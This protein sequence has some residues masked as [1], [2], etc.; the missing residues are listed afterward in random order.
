MTKG[1]FSGT[2]H[3]RNPCLTASCRNTIQHVFVWVWKT[4]E[5]GDLTK[6]RA[7]VA[8]VFWAKAPTWFLQKAVVPS[9]LF[10]PGFFFFFFFFD[11]L[12][13]VF[14]SSSWETKLRFHPFA[15]TE[16]SFT[17]SLRQNQRLLIAF[18]F[19]N[20]HTAKSRAYFALLVPPCRVCLVDV[21]NSGLR[22]C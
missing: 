6:Q 7:E 20:A 21:I 5:H 13:T 9:P 16:G 1:A 14:Q 10:G 22:F 2:L 4:S 8:K 3:F 18:S 15:C 11:L 12:V 19:Q 17:T